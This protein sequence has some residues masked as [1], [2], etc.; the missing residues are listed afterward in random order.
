MNYP[1]YQVVFPVKKTQYCA[2]IHI[3]NNRFQKEGMLPKFKDFLPKGHFFIKD[4]GPTVHSM[5]LEK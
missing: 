2:F 4:C 1:K 3:A 5:Q